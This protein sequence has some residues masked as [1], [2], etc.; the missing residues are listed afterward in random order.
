[1]NDSLATEQIND[2]KLA[3]IERAKFER[4]DLYYEYAASSWSVSLD[5]N[6]H[7]QKY[8]AYI[9]DDHPIYKKIQQYLESSKDYDLKDERPEQFGRYT[10][11]LKN[12]KD[13]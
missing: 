3:S 6:D 2:I 12:P 10:Y 7:G 1:M 9:K 11:T 8:H 4:S 5:L 13:Q